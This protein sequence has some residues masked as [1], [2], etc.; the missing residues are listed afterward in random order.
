MNC[1]GL[2][3]YY[4]AMEFMAAGGKLQRCRVEFLHAVPAPR[5]VLLA[6]EGPGRFLAECL[7]RFPDA[8]VVVVD[9]SGRMLDLAGKGVKSERVEFVHADLL[10]WSAPDESF[11]LV[12]T[13]FFLDCLTAD[14]L[15]RVVE[16][17]GGFASTEGNWLYADFSHAAGGPARWRTR[18]IITLLYGF[19]R[20]VTGL[21]ARDL[22]LPDEAL[23]KAG[24]RKNACRSYEWGLLKSEWW[25]RDPQPRPERSDATA[26]MK[27]C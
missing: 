14:E 2:A 15:S 26:C 1:D 20:V 18:V 9:A 8:E 24:F 27:E 10:E 4:R 16:K 23:K 6:G 5:R 13:H 12:V 3:P 17:I 11:D 19:F 25:T 22:I 21:R 7:R